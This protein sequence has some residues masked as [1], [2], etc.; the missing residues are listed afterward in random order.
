MSLLA[1]WA[2]ARQRSLDRRRADDESAT[3]ARRASFRTLAADAGVDEPVAGSFLGSGFDP[4]LALFATVA[5]SL[6]GPLHVVGLA[7]VGLVAAGWLLRRPRLGRFT[8]VVTD[9]HLLVCDA[10][11]SKVEQVVPRR[12]G[13]VCQGGLSATVELGEEKVY[14]IGPQRDTA[15]RL[16][17]RAT[18]ATT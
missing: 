11:G 16:L 6:V 18:S 13:M 14:V 3:E 15:V 17:G 10:K 4:T 2:E 1:R 12:P 7:I 5:G 9:H 8:V